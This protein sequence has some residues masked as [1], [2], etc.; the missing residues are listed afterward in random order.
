MKKLIALAC[1]ITLP[2][3]ALADSEQSLIGKWS[4]NGVQDAG[5][6]LTILM[7]SNVNFKKNGRFHATMKL[8]F[9]DPELETTVVATYRSNWA[10]KDGYLDEKPTY[11]KIKKLSAAGR[12][13]RHSAF[14]KDIKASLMSYDPDDLAK[15]SFQSVSRVSFITE[16]VT[17]HCQR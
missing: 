2:C 11:V 10:L 14:A 1:F 17:I 15:V 13:M 8:I 9:K 16:D 7:G 4:C 5:D 3:L 6:G 12:D